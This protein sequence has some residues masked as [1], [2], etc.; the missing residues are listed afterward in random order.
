MLA[1]PQDKYDKLFFNK[2]TSVLDAAGKKIKYDD[3]D[4]VK[5]KG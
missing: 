4:E 2:D 3:I 1:L 5:G